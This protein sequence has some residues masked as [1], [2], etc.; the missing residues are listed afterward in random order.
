MVERL[1]AARGKKVFGADANFY[2][3]ELKEAAFMARGMSAKAAH[4]AAL[5]FYQMSP[6]AVYHPSVIVAYSEW[7]DSS[8]FNFWKI[9]R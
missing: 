3:H 9:S 8:W 2:L 7:F 1:Q 5:A 4:N 6:H